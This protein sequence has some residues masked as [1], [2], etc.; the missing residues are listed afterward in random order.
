ME[1]M[2]DRRKSVVVLWALLL[3][4]GWSC[5]AA[6]CVQAADTVAALR[7]EPRDS[8]VSV[9]RILASSRYSG[10]DAWQMLTP[11][12]MAYA[13]ATDLTGVAL[14]YQYDQR[15][16][17]L[18]FDQG[19][20]GH[21]GVF[22]A[23][24][25]LHLRR[26]LTV[27]GM[28]SYTYGRI[29]GVQWMNSS[30]LQETYPYISA[31][32]EG[33]EGI[34][35]T[36]RF[37]GGVDYGFSFG[38]LGVA[39]RYRAMQYH[40]TRDP[41]P[42]NIVS[43]FNLSFGYSVPLG[44]TYSLG[45]VGRLRVY[46]QS[47]SVSIYN[48]QS[49]PDYFL[50]KGLGSVFRRKDV[51]DSPILYRLRGGGGVLQLRPVGGAGFWARALFDYGRLER[52]AVYANVAPVNHYL[53]PYW[54]ASFGYCQTLQGWELGAALQADGEVRQGYDHILGGS[55][56]KEYKD[57]LAVPNYTAARYGGR[58]LLGAEY[59]SLGGVAYSVHGDVVR[60]QLN[61]PFKEVR[62]AYLTQQ[63]QGYYR[64]TLG[65][66]S[67]R[68]GGM[69]ALGMPLSALYRFNVPLASTRGAAMD[70]VRHNAAI[71]TY[72]QIGG[73][74]EVVGLLAVRQYCVLELGLSGGVTVWPQG[75]ITEYRG[76]CS[77][78]ML[79]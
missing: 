78:S 18:R 61:T 27:Y 5:W 65:V 79:F 23:H 42:R 43:D 55:G 20:G 40:R 49:E 53:R 4:L 54:L 33:G 32:L 12:Q 8:R 76:G 11:S 48:P 45:L 25:Y 3:C 38:T 2:G 26:N 10:P 28:A 74:L 17:L 67:L 70:Y 29:R 24:S 57:L 51:S 59:K 71:R 16:K 19:R 72:R 60:E 21:Q 13:Y 68:V 58:L 22:H 30:D 47:S 64:A 62:T 39:V 41:R 31:T 35:S 52:L 69:V 66:H 9:E 77:L 7:T 73:S 56:I 75:A 14:R 50:F 1:S 6:G 15:N 63:L 37:M 34:R 36:Y 46:K 44:K